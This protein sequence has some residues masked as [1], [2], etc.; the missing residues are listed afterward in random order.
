MAR[1]KFPAGRSGR[2]STTRASTIAEAAGPC[3][4]SFAIEIEETGDPRF[5]GV[6]VP[7]IRG[8]TT[9]GRS[10]EDAIA[11]ARDAIALHLGHLADLG[12]RVPKPRRKPEIRIVAAR[13]GRVAA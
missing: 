3:G 13:R 5:Y 10:I 9:S 11:N 7:D 4:L 8:C 6:V 12:L 2:S 1:K